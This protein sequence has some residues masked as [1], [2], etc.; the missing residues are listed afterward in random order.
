M[1]ARC[2]GF[3][4]IPDSKLRRSKQQL[5]IRRPFDNGPRWAERAK[6]CKCATM[7]TLVAGILHI[8][9][10]RSSAYQAIAAGVL[11]S[12]GGRSRRSVAKDRSMAEGQ[13]Q[14]NPG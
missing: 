8:F 9:K 11:Q 5:D 12:C 7:K 6:S 1:A 2:A 3:F 4:V 13:I 14:P 10:S